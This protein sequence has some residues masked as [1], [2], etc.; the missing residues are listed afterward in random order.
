MI[1][2]PVV[3]FI[4]SQTANCVDVCRL[5]ALTWGHVNE[6]DCGAR[7]PGMGR[8]QPPAIV[9]YISNRI[10]GRCMPCTDRDE[11]EKF[12]RFCSLLKGPIVMINEALSEETP[13]RAGH[14]VSVPVSRAVPG[15]NVGSGHVR[16][17]NGATKWP[18]CPLVSDAT[19]L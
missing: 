17:M 14:F 18:R 3:G 10:P 16:A 4:W 6:G 9:D 13:H 12:A 5:L 2:R 8:H 1:W 7:Q 15:H 19:L 11:R